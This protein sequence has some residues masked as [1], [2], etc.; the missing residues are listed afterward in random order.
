MPVGRKNCDPKNLITLCKKCHL[1][2]NH[3]RNYWQKLFT[4]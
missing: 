2:T 1:K 3:N 4:N